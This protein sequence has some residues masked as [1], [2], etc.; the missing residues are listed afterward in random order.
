[1]TVSIILLYY[2]A[3][4]MTVSW[5]VTVNSHV[6]IVLC[7]S[8]HHTRMHNFVFLQLTVDRCTLM[9]IKLNMRTKTFL[10][11]VYE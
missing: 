9:L 10:V 3:L 5:C 8:F 1:V 11:T 4:Q 7:A 2:K 6:Y